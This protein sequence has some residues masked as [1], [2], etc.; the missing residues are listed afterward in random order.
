MGISNFFA[1]SHQTSGG[2]TISLV[3]AGDYPYM[4][5][6]V[7]NE[8]KGLVGK[9]SYRT[10]H[11]AL[12]VVIGRQKKTENFSPCN[13]DAQTLEGEDARVYQT[14]RKLQREDRSEI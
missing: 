12:I 10:I 8:M 7:V 4:R 2:Q 14:F 3:M 9:F 1:R 11:T 6:G 13:V 5:P